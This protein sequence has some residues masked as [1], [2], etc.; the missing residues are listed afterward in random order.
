MK[1]NIIHCNQRKIYPITLG[2]DVNVRT[3]PNGHKPG[4]ELIQ[5]LDSVERRQDGR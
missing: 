4:G 5:F 3:V 2:A 1:M